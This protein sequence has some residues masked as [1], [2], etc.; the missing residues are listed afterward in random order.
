[1]LEAMSVTTF[2]GSK[3]VNGYGI[4]CFSHLR[5]NFVFQR[6]QHLLSRFAKKHDVL[7]IEEPVHHAGTAEFVITARQLRG[8]ERSSLTIIGLPGRSYL[9]VVYTPSR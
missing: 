9:A 3:S 7:F 8:A 5:W 4:V 2:P 6:P 1:M